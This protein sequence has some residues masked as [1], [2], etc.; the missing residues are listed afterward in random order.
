MATV[1]CEGLMQAWFPTQTQIEQK[2][3]READIREIAQVLV[4][5]SS[6]SWSR[7]PR[8]YSVLKII[9]HLKAIDCFVNEGITDIWFP[10]SQKS[11]PS[12]FQPQSARSVFLDTQQLVFNI[13][14]ISLEQEHTRHSHFHDASE[15]PFKKTGE[16][17]QGGFGSVDRVLSTVTYKEYARK[18]LPRGRTFKKNKEVLQAFEKELS[19]LKRLSRHRHVV[20]FIGSYTDPKYVGII[21]SPVADCNLHDYLARSLDN[22]QRSF[23]RT[24]F[25]CLTSALGFL[26]DSHI[27]HKDIKPQNI[28]VKSEEIFLTDFGLAL[29]WNEH[30]RNTTIGP[31]WQT[32]RYGAPEV[33]ESSA[34]NESAD[35]WSL[36]CVFLEMWTVLNSGNVKALHDHMINTGNKK[37]SYCANLLSV[38]SWIEHI[39]SLPGL[40][41]DKV[42]AAWI[43]NTLRHDRGTRW[44]ARTLG[45]RIYEHSNDPT[46]IFAFVGRCCLDEDDSEESVLSSADEAPADLIVQ[47]S[48]R[49]LSR[50]IHE[51]RASGKEETA[52][53]HTHSSDMPTDQSE[54][55]TAKVQ[56]PSVSTTPD[57]SVLS[58]EKSLKENQGKAR[59]GTPLGLS[60]RLETEQRLLTNQLETFTTPGKY[61]REPA[62]QPCVEEEELSLTRELN[63]VHIDSAVPPLSA[64]EGNG[65]EKKPSNQWVFFATGSNVKPRG[66]LDIRDDLL[67]EAHKRRELRRAF[68]AQRDVEEVLGE[69]ELWRAKYSKPKRDEDR[70]QDHVAQ[71]SL[72]KN[73]EK[74]RDSHRSSGDSSSDWDEAVVHPSPA[75]DP[76]PTYRGL[77]HPLRWEKEAVWGSASQPDEERKSGAMR[78]LHKSRAEAERQIRLPPVRTSSREYYEPSRSPR[79]PE[80]RAEQVRRYAL[81]KE[82][83]DRGGIPEVVDWNEPRLPTFKHSTA[84][85]A[86]IRIP[87]TTQRFQ[88]QSSSKN[89]RR[90]SERS[91][92]RFPGLSRSATMPTVPGPEA[93]GSHQEA[94]SYPHPSAPRNETNTSPNYNGYPINSTPQSGIDSISRPATKPKSYYSFASSRKNDLN[95]LH[96]SGRRGA[97]SFHP[98]TNSEREDYP[99]VRPTPSRKTRD[100]HSSND[101]KTKRKKVQSRKN[102]ASLAHSRTDNSARSSQTPLHR[103]VLREPERNRH[104]SPS[105]LGVPLMGANRPELHSS[106]TNTPGRSS[107]DISPVRE[108]RRRASRMYGEGS[109]SEY[110]REEAAE[111]QSDYNPYR[112][113]YAPRYGTEDVRWAPKPEENGPSRARKP[114]LGHT[115]QVY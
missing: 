96:P 107:R 75:A 79:H 76:A 48:S 95:Y 12:S 71:E 66:R 89:R 7:I 105:P 110:R 93:G 90:R 40:P 80:V 57:K 56:V 84:S 3:L 10:F 38:E 88:A 21:T 14:A 114:T 46:A 68:L 31:A 100:S 112:V 29:D 78:Y 65:D 36:G 11:L 41:V 63:D 53:V 85:P 77:Y 34:R 44:T 54:Q 98:D 83:R 25:G 91:P 106:R 92:P 24:F 27:R 72:G 45:E 28:L 16:L 62:F 17:G 113:H 99:I 61:Q 52:A 101:G 115:T 1:D 9:K 73:V 43:S 47:P 8:I 111:D 109:D 5:A 6:V 97:M 69:S 64:P 82:H 49:P 108:E 67:E 37:S 35:I 59:H 13:K 30:S 51:K 39:K 55:S 26:H 58:H 4:R 74:S 87:S 33:A 32:P 81:P 15:I 86:E 70:G 94:K 23:L 20:D 42:P 19:S 18:L 22:G 60:S 103:T 2:P 104:R 50:R 102:K